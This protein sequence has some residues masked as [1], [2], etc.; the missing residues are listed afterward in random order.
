MSLT[1]SVRENECRCSFSAMLS[2]LVA[3]FSLAPAAVLLLVVKVRKSLQRQ[4]RKKRHQQ[5]FHFSFTFVNS[6]SFARGFSFSCII[7]REREYKEWACF[8]CAVD[9]I[10]IMM[11]LVK[12]PVL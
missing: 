4:T 3:Y 12:T 8:M 1:K 9:G 7:S 2:T 5:V 10:G 11:V 6:K